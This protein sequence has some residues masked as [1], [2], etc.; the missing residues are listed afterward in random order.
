MRRFHAYTPAYRLPVGVW[1]CAAPYHF[2]D[3]WRAFKI[4]GAKLDGHKR[5]GCARM[6]EVLAARMRVKE[7]DSLA[8]PTPNDGGR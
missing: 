2:A 5:P 8:Q 4:R 6:I 3:R 1:L 7:P